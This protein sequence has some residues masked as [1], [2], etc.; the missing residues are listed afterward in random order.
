MVASWDPVAAELTS[1]LHSSKG[2]ETTKL[3]SSTFKN[4]NTSCLPLK[5]HP[6]SDV[7][8]R[9]IRSA[10]MLRTSNPLEICANHK[11]SQLLEDQMA[12]Y[13]KPT[14]QRQ[15]V[16]SI[17]APLKAENNESLWCIEPK[18]LSSSLLMRCWKKTKKT[19]SKQ[20]SIA[21]DPLQSTN[22]RSK[23]LSLSSCSQP[24]V[25]PSWK[26]TSTGQVKRPS[27]DISSTWTIDWV[28]PSSSR[29]LVKTQTVRR[30]DA[31]DSIMHSR[32]VEIPTLLQCF[33][34]WRHAT[35]SSASQWITIKLASFWT[36]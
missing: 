32:Q 7:E 26:T 34:R 2:L 16:K 4:V 18:T 36:R 14:S 10:S 28:N 29:I 8:A 11:T 12:R 35:R 5:V 9:R 27:Q 17:E 1:R 33:K 20:S 15:K 22:L 19:S 25:A 30:R 23:A 21:T 13:M 6:T 31:P 3:T 24:S